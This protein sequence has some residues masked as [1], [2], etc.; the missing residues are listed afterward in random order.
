MK[1]RDGIVFALGIAVLGCGAKGMRT[2][3][4]DAGAGT[5]SAKAVAEVASVAEAA[6]DVWVEY[7]VSGDFQGKSRDEDVVL[8]SVGGDGQLNIAARG[9]WYFDMEFEGA[10]PGSHQGKLTV[11]LPEALP[12]AP[13]GVFSRRMIGKGTA[14]VADA[15]RDAL[16]L[17]KVEV[18]FSAAG[19]EN[20]EGRKVDVTGKLACGLFQ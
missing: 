19:L 18:E 20:D 5:T 16:G 10:G 7:T 2:E 14:T 8:C 11:T 15:G 17:R 1:K 9:V 3:G 12:G 6:P 4:D 13:S